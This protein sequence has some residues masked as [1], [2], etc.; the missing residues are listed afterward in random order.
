MFVILSRKK[1]SLL[2]SLLLLSLCVLLWL[3]V[4]NPILHRVC[5]NYKSLPLFPFLLARSHLLLIPFLLFFRLLG[6]I[7]STLSSLSGPALNLLLQQ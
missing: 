5:L 2:L 1:V 7:P 6:T 3:A 4:V